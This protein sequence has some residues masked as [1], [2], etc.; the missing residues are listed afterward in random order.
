MRRLPDWKRAVV[1]V[2]SALIAP[3]GMGCKTKHLL[4]IARFISESMQ[5]G[6]EVILVSSGAVAAGRVVKTRPNPRR[7]GSIVEKQALAA[8]GQSM[9]MQI[10]STLFDAPCA[11]VLLT[12][13][14]LRNRRRFV[15]AKNALKELLKMGVLPIVNENDPVAVEE[16][17]VGD[18]DN[19]AAHVA[20]ATEADL[21]IILTDIDGLYDANPHEVKDAKLIKEVVRITEAT[22]ALA[23]GAVSKTGTG[24]MVTKIQAAEKATLQG[25]PTIIA[26]GSKGGPDQLMH[27]V[28]PGTLFHSDSSPLAAK[29][30]WLRHALE[31]CGSVEVDAGAARALCEQGAS[32]LPSGAIGVRGDFHRGDAVEIMH[33]GQVI[34]KGLSQYGA[35]NLRRILGR[36]SDEIATV[37]GFYYMDAIVHRGDMVCIHKVEAAAAV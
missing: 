15:N 8:V 35:E 17:K 32:L 20:V 22:Y 18:N 13:D 1:K 37:L 10:W 7:R 33:G 28:C 4:P 26:C 5:N 25:I 3:D 11:Q 34:A 9:L 27:G 23:G 12:H 6:R 29:K 16:L 31:T 19:L 14:D 36:R 2:G 24:G 30:H 21:L